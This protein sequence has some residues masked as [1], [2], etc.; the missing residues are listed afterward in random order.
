MITAFVLAAAIAGYDWVGLSIETDKYSEKMSQ[1]YFHSEQE[2]RL[3]TSLLGDREDRV[4]FPVP[5]LPKEVWDKQNKVDNLEKKRFY[6]DCRRMAEHSWT[7]E[8][9]QASL[10]E[11][12]KI[13]PAD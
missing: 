3:D 7:D 4:C 13:R 2:C 12:E 6:A 10:A 11:C 5:S 8:G 1:R 9:K